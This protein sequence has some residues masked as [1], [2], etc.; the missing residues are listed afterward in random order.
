MIG[1]GK[2]AVTMT[3]YYDIWEKLEGFGKRLT[4][5]RVT[6]K[7]IVTDISTG[8]RFAESKSLRNVAR[9]VGAVWPI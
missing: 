1:Q 7:F 2:N 6:H 8:A 5:C 9:K 3:T 4:Y